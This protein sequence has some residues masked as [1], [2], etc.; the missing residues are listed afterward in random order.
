MAD[1][2]K[3]YVL[4]RG[5]RHVHDGAF[6]QPGQVVQLNAAQARAFADKF[7]PEGHEEPAAANEPIDN[8]HEKQDAGAATVMPNATTAVA[9]A[10]GEVMHPDHA[11]GSKGSAPSPADSPTN[12]SVTTGTG[13]GSQPAGVKA[14]TPQGPQTPASN[15]TAPT[16][17]ST[18]SPAT[19]AK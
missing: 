15:A 7:M 9:G 4:R 8:T 17:P 11:T 1:E 3:G 19:K 16:A 10:T 12:K 5:K 2:T 6:V 13:P 18:V 14:P